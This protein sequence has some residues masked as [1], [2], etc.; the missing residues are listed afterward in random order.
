MRER[1]ADGSVSSLQGLKTVLPEVRSIIP[2]LTC[3]RRV[4]NLSLTR[5]WPM[6]SAFAPDFFK[7]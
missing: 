5:N 3:S 7:C 4:Q 1:N 6:L 2:F